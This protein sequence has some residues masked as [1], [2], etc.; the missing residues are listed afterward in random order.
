MPGGPLSCSGIVDTSLC[1]RCKLTCFSLEVTG[2]ERTHRASKRAAAAPRHAELR[3]DAQVCRPRTVRRRR[4]ANGAVGHHFRGR[5]M[6]PTSTGRQRKSGFLRD[7]Q[8]ARRSNEM[9]QSMVAASLH[10]SSPGHT[11]SMTEP[12]S[13]RKSHSPAVS[14]LQRGTTSPSSRAR[15]AECLRTQ[16]GQT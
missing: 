2:A 15:T 1:R 13:V 10:S 7:R 14:T 12:R 8:I 6:K 5:P 11:P 9:P 4:C 16:L 3:P